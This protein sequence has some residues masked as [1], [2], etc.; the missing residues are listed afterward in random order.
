MKRWASLTV[1]LYLLIL[2]TL[3]VPLLMF[4]GVK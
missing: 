2:V 4:G 3:T 1:L